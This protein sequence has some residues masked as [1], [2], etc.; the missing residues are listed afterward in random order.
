MPTLIPFTPS[1]T[2][3]FKF[4]A[5]LDGQQYSI[6]IDWNLFGARYY[7]N[8]YD[9]SNNLIVS[10]PLIGTPLGYQLTSI[11]STANIAVATTAMPHT[12]SVG[13]VVPLTI[14]GAIPNDYNGAFNCTIINNT[15]F[16][17]PVSTIQQSTSVSGNV[18]YTLSMTAGYFKSTLVYF[19]DNNQIVISP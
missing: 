17:F 15:Q 6:R 8:I 10:R 7:L 3:N 1:T 5:T 14:S 19:P 4:Q 18:T 11:T 16:S 13:T 2:S 9:L 12:Y